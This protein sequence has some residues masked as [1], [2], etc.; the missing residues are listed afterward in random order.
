MKETRFACIE[1]NNTFKAMHDKD[2]SLS[3]NYVNS[4]NIIVGINAGMEN[5]LVISINKAIRH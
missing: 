4:N 1:E 3:I 2:K 5:F